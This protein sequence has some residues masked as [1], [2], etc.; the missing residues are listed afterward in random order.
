MAAVRIASLHIYPVKSLRGIALA[1][2]EVQERGLKWDRRWMWVDPDGV[3]I[4]QR[5]YP[6]LSRISTTLT[7]AG[8]LLHDLTG[9]LP[10]ITI[11][12]QPA[13]PVGLEVTIWNDTVPAVTVDPACDRWMSSFLGL[14]LRLVMLPESTRRLVDFRYAHQQE[15]VSFADGYPLLMTTQAS[16]DDLNKRLP[17]PVGMDRFRPNLVLEGTGAWEEDTWT[18]VTAGAVSFDLAKPSARCV[19]TTIDPE[20]GVKGPEPLKTL[21]VFRKQGHKI[22]FGQNLLP[23][24]CGTIRV[25]DAVTT[26]PTLRNAPV[27]L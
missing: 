11:P 1:E 7:P 9:K 18:Q 4:S 24:Q 25:G 6:L 16:L 17:A 21:A 26:L 2:A 23:R 14:P 12:Y 8:I 22:L 10:P 19:M 5:K 20:T 27:P 15:I 3:F 13:A